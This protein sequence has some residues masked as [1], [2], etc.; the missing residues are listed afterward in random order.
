MPQC[1]GSLPWWN[2]DAGHLSSGIGS[3]GRW[4]SGHGLR[5]ENW[6]TP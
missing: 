3:A 1:P 6:D 2:P 4:H 5:L